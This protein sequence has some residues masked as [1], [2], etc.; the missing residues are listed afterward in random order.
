MA[1]VTIC[2]DFAAQENKACHCYHCFPSYVP[3]IDGTRCHDQFSSVQSLSHSWLFATCE[4]QD[5]RPPC[6]SPFPGVLPSSCP[7]NQWCHPTISSS[8][9]LFSFCLQ[10]FPASGSSN[11]SA[12]HIRWPKYWSFSF[13]ISPSSEYS[14]LISFRIDWFDFL[15]VQGTLKSLFQHHSLKALVLWHSA[16]FMVQF[17]HLYM[18]TGKSLAQLYGPQSAIT[19]ICNTLFSEKWRC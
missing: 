5:T 4:W 1:A 6:P 16:F 10:S 2:S 19:L 8:V 13:R 18:T 3:W 9:A 12:L 15:A 11:Q 7:L 17:S 14:V